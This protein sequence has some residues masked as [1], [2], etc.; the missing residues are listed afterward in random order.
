[1]GK[2]PFYRKEPGSLDDWDWYGPFYSDFREEATKQVRSILDGDKNVEQA[3]AD[4]QQLM[5]PVR[6]QVVQAGDIP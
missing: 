2:V 6:K 5:I 3:L 4:L 1:M